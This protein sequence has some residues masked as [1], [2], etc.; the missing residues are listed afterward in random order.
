MQSGKEQFLEQ[1]FEKASLRTICKNAGLTT[2][3][4]Y[5]HFS[6]KEEL[7]EALVEPMLSGF[8][9]MYREVIAQELSD[10]TTGVENEL[11]SITYAV[12]HKDEFRLLFNCSK[13]TKYEGFKEHLIRD[14][15]YP[16]YQ[17]V[18]DRYAGKPVDPALVRIILRMKFEEY[19]ELIY[20]GYTMDE[21]KRLIRQLT[22]FS[23]VGFRALLKTV[24]EERVNSGTMN[25]E[26]ANTSNENRG[27]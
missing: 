8:G 20:G 6:A 22:V 26:K 27:V 16:S 4:F 18:F 11:R 24:D 2:G 23:E 13:G 25:S 17:E 3:A 9:V 14:I 19:M 21:V 15:F 12:A 1:G 10:L 5:T 7:F